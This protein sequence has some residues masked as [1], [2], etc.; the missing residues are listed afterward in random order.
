MLIP[1]ASASGMNSARAAPVMKNAG[2]NTASTHNI[3]NKRGSAVSLIASK[4][5]RAVPD[6]R[7]RC[8]CRFSIATVA[9]STRIPTARASPP[10]VIRLMVWPETQRPTTAAAMLMGILSTTITALRISRK[11]N[12]TINPVKAAPSKPSFAKS[13]M[14]R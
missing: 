5:A 13:M 6:P 4:A 3:A 10:R 12:R 14:A 9:S 2:T 1:T 7:C 11:N 8:T